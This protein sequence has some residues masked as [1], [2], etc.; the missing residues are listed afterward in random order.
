MLSKQF[1]IT[2]LVK[3]VPAVNLWGHSALI[4]MVISEQNALNIELMRELESNYQSHA[5]LDSIDIDNNKWP[6]DQL[7][8]IYT[9]S[10]PLRSI[11]ETR[12]SLVYWE[13]YATI[14]IPFYSQKI[15]ARVDKNGKPAKTAL[16][17]HTF[18]I[19]DNHASS[20][21]MMQKAV[22][23]MQAS[24]HKS[25]NW[26]WMATY[27]SSATEKDHIN[28]AKDRLKWTI[29]VDG[30]GV[31]SPDNMRAWK[32]K[33]AIKIK[34]V[35]TFIN[36]SP[37]EDDAL[38]SVA[39]TLLNS[40]IGGCGIIRIPRIA[41]VSIV[42][43]IH[44]FS[45]C[46][47]KTSIVHVAAYDRMYLCGESFLHPLTKIQQTLLNNYCELDAGN[48]NISIFGH[49]Y[50]NGTSFMATIEELLK[51]NTEIQTWRY[52]YYVKL[53]RLDKELSRHYASRTF[54][55]YVENYLEARYKDETDAWI[56]ATA[57]E[58]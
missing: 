27:T 48:S 43:L 38:H 25:I 35:D 3:A 16:V 28:I 9:I 4:G 57:Y 40:N 58:H 53:L 36:N 17:I 41:S 12:E 26:D 34:T 20:V 47:A 44:L 37:N 6:T 24:L 31:I 46:Y 52:D 22:D 1:D 51:V 23:K 56:T 13:L 32:N 8:Q 10:Y 18:H 11:T 30:E 39:F 2:P 45:Q 49:E 54:T 21:R 5:R 19:C 7:K 14:L 33:I 29:G 50:T 15:A 55:K 42:S